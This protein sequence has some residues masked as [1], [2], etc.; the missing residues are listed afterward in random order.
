MFDSC[1]NSKIQGNIG[2]GSA[3]AYFT[4]N[5]YI[6]SIP[7]TDSQPYDL[8]VEINNKLYKVQVKTSACITKDGNIQ[9][10]LRTTGGNQSFHTTKY[11]DKNECDL[12]FILLNN[13]KQYLIPTNDIDV[14]S[15]ITLGKKYEQFCV[16]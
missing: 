12:L 11:F 10:D 6:V 3:I 8:I 13:G 2:I 5:G 15:T 16:S 1:K 7:I 9:V 14:K 4:M